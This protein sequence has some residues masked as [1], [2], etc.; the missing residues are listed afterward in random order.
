MPKWEKGEN[1]KKIFLALID[2]PLTF[3]ELLENLP[4]SRGALAGHLKELEEEAIIAKA[5]RNKK[6][7]YKIVFDNEEKIM[8]ELKSIHFD[9]LLK[10]VS[11]SIDPMI[12]EVLKSMLD[13]LMKQIIFFKKRELLDKPRLSAKELQIKT[14]EIMKT[15]ASPR[16]QKEMRLNEILGGLRNAPDS[17]FKEFEDLR[18]SMNKELKKVKKK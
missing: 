11:D 5:R 2:N 1:R 14:Y 6:R 18:T 9:I 13:S 10:L 12:G 4:I 7:V 17:V 3:S 8:N 16:L 15:T